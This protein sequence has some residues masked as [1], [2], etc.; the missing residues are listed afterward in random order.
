[1]KSKTSFFN[2]SLLRKDLVRFAPAW[3]LYAVFLILV[4]AGGL[5]DAMSYQIARNLGESVQLFSFINLAYAMLCAQLLMGDLHNS[6]MC[7][8]LHALPIRRESWLLTHFAAGMLFCLIPV[9][10]AGIIFLIALGSFWMAGLLWMG[11]LTLQFLFFFSTGLLAMLLTGN[12]FA[13]LVVYCILNFFAGIALW[14]F[15]A[16]Y[17]PHFHGL[18]IDPDPWLVFCPVAHFVQHEW[19]T[20]LSFGTT[21][22]LRLQVLTGWGYLAICALVALGIVALSMLVYRKRNLEAAGDFLAF[23][24]LNPV[25]LVLYT[26]SAGAAMHLFCQLFIEQGLRFAFLLVGLTVGF[27]TGL[28]LL[29]RTLRVFR[30]RAFAQYAVILAVFGLTLLLTVLDPAGITRWTPKAEDVQSV[31]LNRMYSSDMTEFRH[32]DPAIIQQVISVHQHG[33]QTPN[34]DSNG[35]Q[36]ITLTIQYT[37]KSGRKVSRQYAI[38]TGT[39]AAITLEYVLSQP[40]QLF[41]TDYPTAQAL[42]ERASTV[43][44][45]NNKGDKETPISEKED[46]LAILEAIYSDARKGDLVQEWPLISDNGRE[47]YSV[48]VEDFR[49]PYR[50][51]WYVSVHT[52]AKQTTALLDA[53]TN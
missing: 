13:G 48:Y 15:Y 11:A 30:L 7:N 9:A 1:M 25:F 32:T 10:A 40:E 47:T 22:N 29:K 36:D 33:I 28:M 41:G 12:R 46:I 51:T 39:L 37:M 43:T 26:F 5:L 24:R 16:L 34:S 53:L 50:R 38:D 52:Q 18:I 45:Y 35:E 8:A 4:F 42:A 23:R 31:V 19:F 17:I 21:S 6:R 3:V 20:V 27:L 49:S 44:I 2:T 14:L